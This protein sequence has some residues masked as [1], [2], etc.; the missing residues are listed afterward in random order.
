MDKIQRL[1]RLNLKFLPIAMVLLT[2]VYWVLFYFGLHNY[3]SLLAP[4]VFGYSLFTD[5]LFF[6]YFILSRRFCIFTVVCVY[7]LI[8]LNVISLIG[9]LFFNYK[10][11]AYIY[12]TVI[13]VF[14][15]LLGLALTIISND[16][17]KSNRSI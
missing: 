9:E 16:I 15:L 11:Y 10:D 12:D 3:F 14:A 1:I 6:Y 5:L 17:N 7:A 8:G 13:C 4:D 2:I